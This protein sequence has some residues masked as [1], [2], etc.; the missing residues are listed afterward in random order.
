MQTISL[1]LSD[2]EKKKISESAQ[3]LKE[4][5]SEAQKALEG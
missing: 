4:V 3:S 2:E 5:N 1:Q